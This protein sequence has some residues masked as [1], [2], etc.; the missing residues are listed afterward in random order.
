MLL[1]IIGGLFFRTIRET[2]FDLRENMLFCWMLVVVC[3][4]RMICA[5]HYS[6]YLRL[7]VGLVDVLMVIPFSILYWIN[8]HYFAQVRQ[9]RL[10]STETR[11]VRKVEP[12]LRAVQVGVFLGMLVLLAGCGLD[13]DSQAQLSV[14]TT[15][16]IAFTFLVANII[17]FGYSCTIVAG[18]ASGRSDIA[19]TRSLV[20]MSFACIMEVI[21]WGAWPISGNAL[22][23]TCG[24]DLIAISVLLYKYRS[25]T[26][27][28]VYIKRHSKMLDSTGLEDS[29]SAPSLGSPLAATSASDFTAIE[30]AVAAVPVATA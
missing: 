22:F 7:P 15:R 30:P 1:A 20:V 9:Q 4:V 23:P 16:I 21:F 5:T 25:P 12:V 11:S 18:L 24:F 6:Y 10:A 26:Q 13:A 8:G 29:S 19:L 2:T 3:I 27:D 17:F 28:P 14:V